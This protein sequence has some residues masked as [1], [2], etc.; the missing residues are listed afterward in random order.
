[1]ATCSVSLPSAMHRSYL[2]WFWRSAPSWSV[3][4]FCQVFMSYC[5]CLQKPCYRITRRCH[6]VV[7][8]DWGTS[9]LVQVARV[10][11][12]L[13]IYEALPHSGSET[14]CNLLI[15]QRNM[16]IRVEKCV[17][18]V[19][20]RLSRLPNMWSSFCSCETRKKLRPVKKKKKVYL[21][22]DSIFGFFFLV[23]FNIRFERYY[24]GLLI[25]Q[26]SKD[27]PKVS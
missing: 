17:L 21:V 7:P 16:E 4:R 1:M 11:C 12:P 13:C 24:S 5:S 3:L 18:W 27:R 10:S 2:P 8:C 20:K 26:L 15:L 25:I 6:T 23:W 9:T 19:V 14:S 22:I